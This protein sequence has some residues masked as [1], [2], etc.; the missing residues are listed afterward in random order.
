MLFGKAIYVSGTL[1][2][3]IL[4]AMRHDFSSQI[5]I[6]LCYA[7]ITV[8]WVIWKVKNAAIFDKEKPNI[9]VALRSI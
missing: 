4:H 6:L 7:I 1:L 2:D 9:H 5:F 8:V 3:L